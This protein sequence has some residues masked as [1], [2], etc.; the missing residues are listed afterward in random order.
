[1]REIGHELQPDSHG[2]SERDVF[3]AVRRKKG[4]MRSTLEKEGIST[5]RMGIAAVAKPVPKRMLR[6]IL[7]FTFFSAWR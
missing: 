1:M 6:T 4:D 2:A 3:K 7:G 5:N